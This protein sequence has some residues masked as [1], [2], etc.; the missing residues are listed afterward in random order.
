[1]KRLLTI[2]TW[3]LL[4]SLSATLSGQDA[5]FQP[6][7]PFVVPTQ[8]PEAE[9]EGGLMISGFVDTY[10]QFSFSEV[11]DQNLVFPT[12][13]TDRTNEFTLGMVN[14]MLSK[15]LG[16]VGFVGQVGF[17]PRAE[18]ANGDVPLIQQLYVTYA[19]TD[20]ITLSMGNFGTFVGYEIIDAPGNVN[21]STSYLFSNGPF[22]HTGV[23]A[24]IAL[25]EKFG[26][27]VGIFN[28]TDSKFDEVAGKH[29]GAQLSTELGGLSAYL[30]FLYGKAEEGPTEREDVDDFQIDLTATYEVSDALSLGLNVSDKSSSMDGTEV[31]G[32][33][34]AALYATITTSD[35]FGIGLRGEVFNMKD[36]DDALDNPSVLSLTA[37]GNITLGDL[38]LIPEIR[39]DSGSNGATFPFESG[40]LSTEESVATFILA[41]VYSF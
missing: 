7:E 26:A 15:E 23:K 21:Y 37:S 32:F 6:T 33:T 11:D 3:C 8:A 30:N 17:G 41:A 29:L 18:A 16:K 25:S 1:M 5:D 12:S 9:V 34:G 40:D 35:V 4:G 31:G 38:R 14:L 28:D 13:F 22:F 20:A 36:G 10:T 39:F 27:M 2:S 19:P 24:D